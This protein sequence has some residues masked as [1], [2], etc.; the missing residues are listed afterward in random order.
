ME[1]EVANLFAEQVSLGMLVQNL[2]YAS[3]TVGA[4]FVVIGLMLIDVGGVRRRNIFNAT[5]EKMVGFFIGFTAYFLIGF[6]FWASQYY[7]MVDYTLVDTIK[8]WWAGGGLSNSMAQNVD[9]AVFPGL[10][11]FQIFIFFL[12]CFAGIVNVL[13]H[14]AVS[15]RMKASAYY[16]TAFVATIVSSIL[17]WI[18]WGSVG[19]LTNLGF[20]DFFGVGFVYLFPAGMAMVFSRTLRPRPGMFS[21]HPK[22]SE[23]RPPNL[24]LLTVGIMTIFAGLPMIILSCLF[25]FD[26][27]ALAVSVTMAD[28]SV[29]IAFNNYGAAWAGGALMGAVLAYSTRKFSYLLLG[30]LAGYV[31]GASGFDVYVPWQMFLVA[32]GAPIVAYVIYEFL[33]KR[34]IDEHKLL[35]LF[36]GVGSYGLIMTGLLHIGVPRGGYLGI[37]EGAYAFQHGEIGV[38]MQ[39]VGIVVSLGFGIITALVLSFVLKHTTGLDVSDDAQ[40][41]GLDK[42]YW[43]IEPDVDPVTDN[44][45]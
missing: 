38:V 16:I 13:L 21:A 36:A 26:P 5:I 39:L 44:K 30:P 11:N 25:F 37:E 19:P 28:T 43:D 1:T 4:I 7:I 33:Q 15:E 34:Q 45:S 23:Y 8:D 41:E 32:L 9:P 3:G 20:H 24:G 42:V 40:A 27:G 17:S 31:A 12:A 22:V 18:T 2:V 10:N 14:F 6:A 29:G 35:P